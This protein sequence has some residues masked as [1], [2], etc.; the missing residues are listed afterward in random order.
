MRP[1]MT[2]IEVIT[3]ILIVAALGFACFSAYRWIW[4][5]PTRSVD[6]QADEMAQ[7]YA[8]ILERMIAHGRG[9]NADRTRHPALEQR[10]SLITEIT[11]NQ[12]Y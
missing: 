2:V 7:Q 10:Q 5:R 4:G 1:G 9:H 3:G 8:L 6:A 11:I 12:L